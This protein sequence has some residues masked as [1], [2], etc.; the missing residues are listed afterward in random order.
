[1]LTTEAAKADAG[2]VMNPTSYPPLSPACLAAVLRAVADEGENF[3]DPHESK[4]SAI[5]TDWILAIAAELEG[6][7]G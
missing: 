5:R 1:M 7:R 3:Y 2:G 6:H 4:V